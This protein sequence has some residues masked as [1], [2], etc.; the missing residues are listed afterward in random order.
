MERRGRDVGRGQRKE[1][2][3]EGWRNGPPDFKTW[4][5]QCPC[6][7]GIE[8]NAL[9]K[10]CVVIHRPITIA[11]FVSDTCSLCAVDIRRFCTSV[12]HANL[13]CFGGV[14]IDG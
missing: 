12:L 7:R 5:R 14:L 11:M 13:L 4:M 1:E 9:R 2:E 6:I 3:K 10:C 8:N